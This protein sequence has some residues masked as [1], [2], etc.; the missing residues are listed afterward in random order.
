MTIASQGLQVLV[1]CDLCALFSHLPL[2]LLDLDVLF[3]SF[4]IVGHMLKDIAI[5]FKIQ[6]KY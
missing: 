1:D 2:F 6:E 3:S 5:N 4:K